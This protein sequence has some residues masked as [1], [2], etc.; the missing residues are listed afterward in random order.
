M[1]TILSD[2][3]KNIAADTLRIELLRRGVDDKDIIALDNPYPTASWT[4]MFPYGAL[5]LFVGST[6]PASSIAQQNYFRLHQVLEARGVAPEDRIIW[7]GHSAG[8]QMGLTM[9]HLASHWERYPALADRAARYR[10]DMVITLGAPIAFLELP[11]EIKLRHYYSPQDKVVRLASCYGPTFLYAVGFPIGISP[12]PPRL[13][14]A[15]R[16]RVF[17]SVEHPNWDIDGRVV[18]R[19]VRETNPDYRPLWHS[20]VLAPGLG[21]AL[22]RMVHIGLETHTQITLEDPPTQWTQ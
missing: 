2:R 8:G 9:A 11:A 20:P 5:T 21:N 18:D 1:H 14:P 4:N 22:V 7:I 13:N 17:A 6:I 15:D 10:F 3:W 12:F 19:I 16:I